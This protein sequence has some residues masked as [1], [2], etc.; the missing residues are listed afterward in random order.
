MYKLFIKL[1][2]FR[3]LDS[4]KRKEYRYSKICKYNDKIIAKRLNTKQKWGV[5][6]S[7]FDG[8]ELLEKSILCIR[9]SVDY[10]N[11]VYQKISWYGNK[12]DDNLLP[13]LIDLKN[14]GLIDEI[15]EYNYIHQEGRSGHA[16]KY[17]KEKRTLG[18]KAAIKNNCTYFM[19]MDCDEFYFKDEVEKAKEFIL[20]NNISHSF[21]LLYDYIYKPIYRKLNA[22]YY[23]PFFAKINRFS[24]FIPFH[25]FKFYICSVDQTRLLN[26]LIIFKFFNFKLYGGG[27][28]YRP[29][30]LYG[31]AMHHMTSIRK[32]INI[33][34]QNSSAEFS[35]SEIKNTYEYYLNEIKKLENTG[36]S[37]VIVK[38]KN[39]FNIDI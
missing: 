4:K 16:P 33:K 8:F 13:T 24:S 31:I 3:F 32:N 22:D 30:I 1:L 17:E 27:K 26:K 5:S 20:I 18:L 7:V 25:F 2:S 38:V 36:T 6:Y 23:I 28:Y 21:V 14:K 34:I 12:C 39:Y 9:E 37:D 35:R 19:T 29:F 15:I 10:V 11:V